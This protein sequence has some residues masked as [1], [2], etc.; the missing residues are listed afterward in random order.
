MAVYWQWMLPAVVA[1]LIPRAVPVG[2]RELQVERPAEGA[3][4][5]ACGAPVNSARGMAGD[6]RGACGAYLPWGTG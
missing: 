3:V 1:L 4:G 6:E 5:G 2:Y